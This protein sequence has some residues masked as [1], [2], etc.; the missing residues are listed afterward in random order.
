MIVKMHSYSKNRIFYKIVDFL[1]FERVKGAIQL[2]NNCV[3]F[4]N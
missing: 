1:F 4:N 3:I 2:L